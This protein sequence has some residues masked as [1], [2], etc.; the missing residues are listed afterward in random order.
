MRPTGVA[1]VAGE[2]VLSPG[3][4]IY[5]A[6]R[7]SVQAVICAPGVPWE[8]GWALAVVGCESS[9][10]PLAWATEVIDGQ[11]YYFHGLW[12]IVSTSPDPGPLADPVYNTQRAAEKYRNG[13]ASHWPHCGYLVRPG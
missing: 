1:A 6:A 5:V 7:R 8:C 2:A 10:Q 9:F 3:G 12:Q 4:S 13:G 11:R